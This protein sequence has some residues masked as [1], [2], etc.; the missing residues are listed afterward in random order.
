[1]QFTKIFMK[2]S[3]VIICNNGEKNLFQ[4]SYTLKCDKSVIVMYLA[5]KICLR[6]LCYKS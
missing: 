1:M 4:E 2:N 6:H 5:F 3:Y